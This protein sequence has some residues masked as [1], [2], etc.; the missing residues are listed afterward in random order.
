MV[1][2]Q[3]RGGG[4]RSGMWLTVVL[5][6]QGLMLGLVPPHIRRRG[7]VMP[8]VKVSGCGGGQAR[9]AGGVFDHGTKDRVS[10]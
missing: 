7:F 6:G 3:C 2:I 4:V 1:S 9:C 10:L 8:P 5:G